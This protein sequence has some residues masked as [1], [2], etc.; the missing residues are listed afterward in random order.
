MDISGGSVPTGKNL[1]GGMDPWDEH[2]PDTNIWTEYCYRRNGSVPTG[3]NPTG[4]M[5][6]G[7]TTKIKTK[8]MKSKYVRIS[9]RN[10]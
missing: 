7:M 6:P 4:G 5:E 10:L 3:T 2:K 1:T 9:L 8:Y